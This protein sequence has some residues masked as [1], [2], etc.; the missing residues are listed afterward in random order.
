MARPG[1]S[2]TYL[3]TYFTAYRVRIS[4][5]HHEELSKAFVLEK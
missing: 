5:Y 3:E 1:K 4:W 2:R